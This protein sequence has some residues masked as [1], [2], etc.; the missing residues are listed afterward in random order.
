MPALAH[1]IGPAGVLGLRLSG[2]DAQ[3]EDGRYKTAHR[4]HRTAPARWR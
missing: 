1:E 4:D 2:S 3:E